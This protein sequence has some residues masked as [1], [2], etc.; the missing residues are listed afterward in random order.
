MSTGALAGYV[1]ADIEVLRTLIGARWMSEKGLFLSIPPAY[2]EFIGAQ[3]KEHLA[4][5]A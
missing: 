2:T 3:V 4:V 1:P 5:A